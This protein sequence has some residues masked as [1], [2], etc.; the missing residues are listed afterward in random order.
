VNRQDSCHLNRNK[1]SSCNCICIVYIMC[2]VSLIVCV[3]LCA[4]FYLSAVCYF[5]CVIY[6]LCL[7]VVPLPPGKN[8][9]AVKINNNNDNKIAMKPLY[10][11]TPVLQHSNWKHVQLIWT[12]GANK[13]VFSFCPWGMN[14]ISLWLIMQHTRFPRSQKRSGS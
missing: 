10:H 13:G 4:K 7:I 2:S 3:V 11:V 8:Q 1:Y 14:I 5:V 6:V 9:F 12:L